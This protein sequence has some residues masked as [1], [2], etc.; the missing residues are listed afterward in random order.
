MAPTAISPPWRGSRLPKNTM[1]RK[2]RK[3][4]ITS[5]QAHSAAKPPSPYS[6]ACPVSS[7]AAMAKV[8]GKFMP[9]PLHQIEFVDVGGGSV[10]EDHQDDGQ[11]DPHFG[12]R[13]RDHQD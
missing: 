4:T 1:A 11:A 8:V 5:N 13:H 7:A 9:L 2:A 10:A 3:G 12:G 6:T